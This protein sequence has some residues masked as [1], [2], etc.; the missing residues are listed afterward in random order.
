[1]FGRLDAAEKKGYEALRDEDVRDF[2]A[3]MGRCVLDLGSSPETATD[4]RIEAVR[5]GGNLGATAGIAE[6]LLQSHLALD[7]LPALPPSW[8][9]G[10]VK[11][12]RARGAREVDITWKHGKLAEAVVR[13]EHDG[14][15]EVVG[16]PLAV[17]WARSE[18]DLK[19]RREPCGGNGRK[20]SAQGGEVQ[21]RGTGSGLDEVA[22]DSA[23]LLGIG[24]HGLDLHLR[25][26]AR[27]A[28]P[29]RFVDFPDQSGPR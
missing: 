28:Q 19:G 6:C 24:D 26:T 10:C 29:V 16:E 25:A 18:G 5:A 8:K 21:I 2:S 22:E 17:G 13:P 3:L 11:G 15:I 7:F 1:V 27:A 14:T 20:G 9:E 23:D 12:M 4:E